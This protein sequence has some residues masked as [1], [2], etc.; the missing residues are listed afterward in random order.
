MKVGFV[1]LLAVSMLDGC[2]TST[3]T[4]VA[5]AALPQSA[6]TATE[7]VRQLKQICIVENPRV[8]RGGE[9]LD[10]YR[11]ALEKKGYTVTVVQKNPQ[12]SQCPLYTRYTAAGGFD[13]ALMQLE[14]YREGKPVG[15]AVSRGAIDFESTAK[16]LV[17]RLFP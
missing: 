13:R 6:A 11:A 15:R 3:V 16:E 17:D 2:T 5:S 1:A 7:P 14:V 12:P 4:P 10:A 9:F 8:T